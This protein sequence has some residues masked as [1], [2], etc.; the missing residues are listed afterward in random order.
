MMR[1]PSDQE[2]DA[3]KQIF[4]DLLSELGPATI[5]VIVAE[6]I[7]RRLIP[8]HIMEYVKRMATIH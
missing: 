3:L 8:K 2:L 6:A 4:R 1:I 5:D 7:E